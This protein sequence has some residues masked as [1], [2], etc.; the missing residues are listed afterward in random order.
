[1]IG[2]RPSGIVREQKEKSRGFV[3]G[4]NLVSWE[5]KKKKKKKKKNFWVVFKE[6]KKRPNP[7]R[8][9]DISWL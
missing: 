8:H 3:Q 6:N 1:V 5:K 9:C 7:M 4:P 2:E